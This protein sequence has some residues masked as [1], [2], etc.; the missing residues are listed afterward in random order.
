MDKIKFQITDVA[1]C[2]KTKIML[3][4]VEVVLNDKPLGHRVFNGVNVIPASKFDFAEFDLFT[5]G[6]GVAG[7]AGFHTEVIQNKK[8]KAVQWTFPNDQS[9]NVNKLIYEFE[10]LDFEG[11]IED[12]RSQ[13]LKLEKLNM[14][15]T[16]CV[17]EDEGYDDEE[18]E[19]KNSFEVLHKLE[20]SFK[21]SEDHYD[22]TEKYHKMLKNKFSQFYGKAFC[23][24]YNEKKSEEIQFTYFILRAMNQ[25]PNKKNEKS[26]L[27]KAEKTANAIIEYFRNQN[28]KPLIQIVYKEYS[29]FNLEF[30]GQDK[31]KLLFYGTFKY[32]LDQVITKEEFEI[33]KVSLAIV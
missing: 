21:W 32:P 5:C 23:F 33:D 3:Y 15:L 28:S 13:M 31:E 22:V 1:P 24:E 11:Q 20:E 4:D 19:E 25:W 18:A 16:M 7:C 9:Y 30:T 12:L 14:H 10:R 29:K 6:C 26:F 27:K 17:K 2:E 8:E